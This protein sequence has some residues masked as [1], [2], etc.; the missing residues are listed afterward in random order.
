MINEE[1][2]NNLTVEQKKEYIQKSKNLRISSDII[3]YLIV[4]IK[5][6][7][8]AEQC[9][10]NRE[11]LCLSSCDIIKIISDLNDINFTKKCIKIHRK[12]D[13]NS[14]H[15]MGLFEKINNPSFT[16]E[17]LNDEE[18]VH[19]LDSHCIVR[20]IE[21]SRNE[22]L[23]KRCIKERKKWGFTPR[24]ICWLIIFIDD[25]D[26]T[27]NA[28]RNYN[29]L[30][31]G[32]SDLKCIINSIEDSQFL[33]ECIKDR[34]KY[35]WDPDVISCMISGTNDR[36]IKNCIEHSEQFGI[37]SEQV[38]D[39]ILLL[40]EPNYT[41][42]C[43]ESKEFK[44][45][46]S[47]KATLI[48]SIDNIQ[49]TKKCIKEGK[50]N[51]DS[52]EL[53]MLITSINND[54]YTKECIRN[55]KKI[56]LKGTGLIFLIESVWNNEFSKE[57][58]SN[59]YK[60][61]LNSMG[62]LSL[63]LSIEN[64]AYIK[65]CLA[66]KEN[67]PLDDFGIEVLNKKIQKNNSLKSNVL[68]R[69]LEENGI[70]ENYINLPPEM[71]IGIEIESEGDNSYSL[72]KL[73]NKII[74]NWICKPDGSLQ[75]GVEIVSPI[76]NT[77]KEST[78]EIYKM[79]LFLNKYEQKATNRCG[80]HIHIG[81][82]YL[83]DVQAVQNLVDLWANCEKSLFIISNA[84][85]EIPRNSSIDFATPISKKIQTALDRGYV[86]LSDENDLEEFVENLKDVQQKR[87]SSINFMNLGRNRSILDKLY[88]SKNKP[89]KNTIEFRL[90]NS[91]LNPN[92]W[93]QN[94]NLYGGIVKAA[95]DLY[96]INQKKLDNIT[97]IDK[98]KLRLFEKI[99]NDNVSEEDK[100]NA[101]L[102]LAIPPEKRNIYIKRYII[103]KKLIEQNKELLNEMN[104]R[105]SNKKI[106]ISINQSGKFKPRN[107]SQS[108]LHNKVNGHNMMQSEIDGDELEK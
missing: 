97:E 19:T 31:L 30:N 1:L 55:A 71:T 34:E 92:I 15:I 27:K 26:Y 45:S 7:S 52:N 29:K 70:I 93:V 60:T 101:L 47:Q 83:T 79:C 51:F 44:F 25:E 81:A 84:E 67:L 28:I 9:F 14:E 63:I 20:L 13:L 87:Y 2:L 49:Y 41:K 38:I 96:E 59:W 107:V 53:S 37:G 33:K 66:N 74:N 10:Q 104:T 78:E 16:L 50:F 43:I 65:E 23:A 91:T 72:N 77:E 18:I 86:N 90:S 100:L 24:D 82:D 62:I 108:T 4:S 3:V 99:K 6:I 40:N 36:Y 35:G 89:S 54:D 75:Y 8:Y 58:I 95:Q 68:D 32:I 64:D 48:L 80:G 85:G 73:S 46:P 103:N 22:E 5:D 17:C 21:L 56:G 98:I 42:K 106:N 61:G 94:I 12:F 76:L 39:L 105:I 102:K 88:E 11:Q 69:L 57:C